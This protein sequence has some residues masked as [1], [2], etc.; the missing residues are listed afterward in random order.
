MEKNKHMVSIGLPVFNGEKYIKD[1]LDSIL[2][3]TYS[4]FE[5]IISDNASTDRTRE[6]CR[7]YEFQDGRIRYYRNEN[8]LGA[9]VNF[10]RVFQLSSGEY[11]K[12]AAHDDLIA[13]DFLMKCVEVLSR[14]PSL[15]LSCPGIKIIDESGKILSHFHKNMD[16]IDSPR[17]Q[18]RFGGLVMADIWCF[19]VFG[20]IRSKALEKTRLIAGFIASDRI[21]RAEL[22]LIGRFCEIPEYLF[23]SRDHPERSIR[24]MPAHHLRGAWFDPSNSSRVVFPHWRIFL[25]YLK[26]VRRVPLSGYERRCCYMHLGRWVGVRM[27]WARM[28]SDLIIAIWPESWKVFYRLTGG[29]K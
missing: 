19:E 6:I 3:Q 17:P 21:L 11:F 28:L 23:F 8:N 2:A 5:L 15:V 18:D 20:L 25:E 13:P 7:D 10:N 4:N 16:H 27:N 12:W 24:A 26:C 14:D 29:E 9:A 22:G 1:A